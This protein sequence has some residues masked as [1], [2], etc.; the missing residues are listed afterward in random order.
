MNSQDG[1]DVSTT[2]VS[3]FECE[4]KVCVTVC[5]GMYVCVCVCVCKCLRACI[6]NSQV[7]R[8]VPEVPLVPANHE[9]PG[10]R[11]KQLIKICFKQ[12]Q[13]QDLFQK[14]LNKYSYM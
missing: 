1:D 10:E 5:V 13:H 7:A 14:L 9:V 8:E 2:S 4:M 6:L 11:K 12:H 3:E